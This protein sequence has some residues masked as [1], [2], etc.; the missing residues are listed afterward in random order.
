MTLYIFVM[1]KYFTAKYWTHKTTIVLVI[2]MHTLVIVYTWLNFSFPYKIIA[3]MVS[4]ISL[5]LMAYLG[6]I[7]IWDDGIYQIENSVV[8]FIPFFHSVVSS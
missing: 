4:A 8:P 1:L 2:L 6:T 7:K 5:A 3:S